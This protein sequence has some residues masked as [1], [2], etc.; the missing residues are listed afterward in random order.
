SPCLGPLRRGRTREDQ[1][2]PAVSELE[3]PPLPRRFAPLRRRHR[4]SP[5]ARR[6]VRRHDV[7][8]LVPRDRPRHGEGGCRAVLAGALNMAD[9]TDKT[10][11]KIRRAAVVGGLGLVVQLAAALHWTPM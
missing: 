5:R 7:V 1:A 6:A 2:L 9:S 11:R 8:S 10:T 4:A 3:L